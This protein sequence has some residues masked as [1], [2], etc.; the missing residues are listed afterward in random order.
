M[1]FLNC[2]KL[3]SGNVKNMLWKT[4][5]MEINGAFV[6]TAEGSSLPNQGWAISFWPNHEDIFYVALYIYCHGFLEEIERYKTIDSENI[7]W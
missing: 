6:C 5:Y 7:I 1:A 4:F 3:C 2:Q